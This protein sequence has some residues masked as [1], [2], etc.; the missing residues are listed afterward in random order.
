MDALTHLLDSPPP[1]ATAASVRS[2]KDE[3][4]YYDA[5]IEAFL[6]GVHDIGERV[7]TDADLHVCALSCP[8]SP[9]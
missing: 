7:P 8:P 5:L 2:N 3:N 4:A 6:H 1:A 9:E